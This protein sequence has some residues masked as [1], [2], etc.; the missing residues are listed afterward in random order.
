M[1]HRYQK[2]VTCLIL[3]LGFFCSFFFTTKNV[4]A[5]DEGSITSKA[6][7][8]G[9]W[10][11]L[12]IG[13]LGSSWKASELKTK[14]IINKGADDAVKYPYKW[15][16]ATDNNT[17]CNQLMF[18]QKIPLASQVPALIPSDIINAGTNYKT[19]AQ[20]FA[21][22]SLDGN[23]GLGYVATP[24]G[25]ETDGDGE[26]LTLKLVSTKD[27]CNG[28][29]P[30]MSLNGKVV[31]EII[32]PVVAKDSSGKK[33]TSSNEGIN[34]PAPGT[35]GTVEFLTSCSASAIKVTDIGTASKPAYRIGVLNGSGGTKINTKIDNK[36]GAIYNIT[37]DFT[38][39]LGKAKAVFHPE[40]KAV[41]SKNI[42]FASDYLLTW[43]ASKDKNLLIGFNA[44][45]G[46]S[47]YVAGVTGYAS[48][49]LSK[50]ETYDLYK[51]YLRDVL[52][53]SIIC[54]GEPNYDLYA[55]ESDINWKAGATC[56]LYNTGSVKIPKNLYGVDSNYHFTKKIS[57]IDDIRN[58]LRDLGDLSGLNG[59]NEGGINDTMPD[60]TPDPDDPDPSDPSE[61]DDSIVDCDSIKIEDGSK[62]GAMQWILCPTM[63]NMQYT[64]GFVEKTLEGMLEVN[65]SDYSVGS[66]TYTA[67]TYMQNIANVVMVVLLLLII[68]SQVTGYG[69]DNYGIKKM[70][71]RLIV[72][73]LVINLSFYICELAIDLSNIFGKGLMDMFSSF[74]SGIAGE[75]I[76][77]AGFLRTM[78]VGLFTTAAG[79]VGP[80]LAIGTTV[81]ATIGTASLAVPVIIAAIVILA[82]IVIAVVIMFLMLGARQIIIILC[83][84]LA[85]LAFAAFILPNAQSLFKKWWGLFKAAIIIYPLCGAVMGLSNMLRSMSFTEEDGN[86]ITVGMSFAQFII[87]LVLP[88]LAF[89]LLPMLLKNAI[90]ALGR[91]G[92]ALTSI[93]QTARN[94]GRA[95]G[96]AAMK[97]VQN[98]QRYKDNQADIARKQ[99]ERRA[100]RILSRS[101]SEDLQKRLEQAKL[102]MDA[103]PNSIRA[104]REYE[105]ALRD[106]RRAARASETLRKLGNEDTA[107]A[108][109]LAEREYSGRSDIDLLNDL[110]TA[111]DSGD[112]GRFDALTNVLTSRGGAKKVADMVAGKEIFVKDPTGSSRDGM[113]F[114]N[115]ATEKSFKAYQANLMQNSALKNDTLNKSSDVYQMVSGGGYGD[116][117]VRHGIE[118]HSANNGLV[119]RY[120][121]VA[122]QSTNTLKRMAAAGNGYL[123]QATAQAILNSSDPAINSGIASDNDKR[124][125]L[126]AIATGTM[127]PE[128]WSH[129]NKI[130]DAAKLY[131]E[132]QKVADELTP[133]KLASY[134]PDALK[135]LISQAKMA[136]TG[137]NLYKSVIKA[138]DGIAGDSAL[139]T[140]LRSDQMEMFSEIR[141][142]GDPND[143]VFNAKTEFDWRHGGGI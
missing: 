16:N 75:D 88:Y 29:T 101:N 62:I 133:G 123:S 43:D 130:E 57:S 107:A 106:Q 23:G 55:G 12:K 35:K 105:S 22:D 39:S 26:R 84:V 103:N 61:G 131:K 30:T 117:N 124:E 7:L 34:V 80:G 18:G 90:S 73:A 52:K 76:K 81:A 98:S 48:L 128:D 94:S 69:I 54:E 91:I 64:A 92:G 122:T 6:T 4:L 104:R 125:V 65:S 28:N 114:K 137:S 10:N 89:F 67:W 96:Q 27:Q 68:F 85:P 20:F 8:E 25:S 127:N 21:G 56:K 118:Y 36:Q 109:I 32:F 71:P 100:N 112:T 143:T 87:M 113:M 2:H 115:E 99:Q 134:D 132:N 135:A 138:T 126:E 53:A 38:I 15:T 82:V 140:N 78:I 40:K 24:I 116:D 139:N 70:L 83:V 13:T 120:A 5:I 3:I 93:G 42:G 33:M 86:W 46:A 141:R 31:S 102:D 136:G 11:C 74:G 129:K 47:R 45:N 51:H 119:S 77:G 17:N 97:G 9:V 58:T 111:W 14:F 142:M 79:G 60:P 108:T 50:Q 37:K 66:N 72:L 1:M 49:A 19:V 95:I 110:S 59:S 121:D 63:N 44:R 41:P